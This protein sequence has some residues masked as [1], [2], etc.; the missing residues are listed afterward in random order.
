M[1]TEIRWQVSNL[2][3]H[4]LEF[5]QFHGP[6]HSPLTWWLF[7]FKPH[8]VRS[9]N[10]TD[11]FPLLSWIVIS[12]EKGLETRKPK[13][14]YLMSIMTSYLVTI[15][16]SCRE[17]LQKC[18]WLINIQ[19]FKRK[20]SGIKELVGKISGKMVVHPSV[21]VLLIQWEQ[22]LVKSTALNLKT[23]YQ[24]LGLFIAPSVL[25]CG[26]TAG[27]RTSNYAYHVTAT[28]YLWVHWIAKSAI[29]QPTMP[30]IG[31]CMT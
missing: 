22:L 21:I 18:P 30:E 19:L 15:A 13:S 12:H 7:V 17:R 10:S 9:I 11:S 14:L 27:R 20:G 25:L 3:S 26:F 28:R 5:Y 4:E 29:C 24:K 8:C 1:L 16:K 23:S 2:W 6:Y 31:K